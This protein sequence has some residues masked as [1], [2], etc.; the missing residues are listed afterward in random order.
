MK[1]KPKNSYHYSCPECHKEFGLAAIPMP[2]FLAE[3]LAM[4]LSREVMLT[5][6]RACRT[7]FTIRIIYQRRSGHKFT[8]EVK[9]NKGK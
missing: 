8:N 1:R 2:D 6:C 5:Y 7:R 9:E 4:K 3:A